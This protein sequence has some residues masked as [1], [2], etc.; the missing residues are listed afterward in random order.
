M[1]ARRFGPS[2]LGCGPGCI[3]GPVVCPRSPAGCSGALA[4]ECT[5]LYPG[6]R[7]TVFDTPDVVRAAKEHFSFLEDDRIRF[8]EGGFACAVCVHG[9][10]GTRPQASRDLSILGLGRNPAVR[11]TLYGP[12]HP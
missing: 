9:D 6:C 10:P 5:A 11:S 12:G 8:W 1:E 7:V 3:E 4:K 2:C